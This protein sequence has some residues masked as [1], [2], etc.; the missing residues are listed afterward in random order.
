MVNRMVEKKGQSI[1]LNG[2]TWSKTAM[3]CAILL[4]AG[5]AAYF[6]AS[7]TVDISIQDRLNQIEMRLDTPVNSSLS[8]LQKPFDY[9]ISPVDAYYC[10]QNGTDGKLN[11]FST[12]KTAVQAAAVGNLTSGGTILLKGCS[13]AASNITIPAGIIVEERYQ[14]N[15][16]YYSSFGIS[17]IPLLPYQAEA[18]K[19]AYSYI[20]FTWVDRYETD[21]GYT[22]SSGTV[23]NDSV[24]VHEGFKAV[25]YTGGATGTTGTI[26]KAITVDYTTKNWDLWVYVHNVTRMKSM[27]IYFRT[28]DTTWNYYFISSIFTNAFVSQNGWQAGWNHLSVTHADFTIGAGAPSWAAINMVRVRVSWNTA[29]QPVSVT[30]DDFKAIS[31]ASNA[32]VTI[33][34]DD[35]RSDLWTAG[36]PLMDLY[37]Y[38]GDCAIPISWVGTSTYLTLAQCQT[39]YSQGWELVSHTVTHTTMTGLSLSQAESEMYAS[40]LWL[41]QNGFVSGSKFFIFPAQASNAALSALA[42][43]Y[44]LGIFTWT[45]SYGAHFDNQYFAD[46]TQRTYLDV[47]NWTAGQ[48]TWYPWATLQGYLDSL[49]ASKGYTTILIHSVDQTIFPQLL[50]YLY[51]NRV[52]VVLY[53]QIVDGISRSPILP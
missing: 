27:Q 33:R 21:V 46:M 44:F 6:G 29:A 10:L 22:V 32:K 49:I 35:A 1:S 19:T 45:D 50:A 51:A 7:V 31:Q 8:G 40:R 34:F 2:L 9:I 17:N 38:K 18:F 52:E 43:K 39:L 41:L 42:N 14:G 11:W 28:N 26:D 23:A 13:L 4:C 3:L 53:S 15:V 30:L 36:K 25:N 24:N 47:S 12:N 16:T 5:V 37:Q 20:N 48:T